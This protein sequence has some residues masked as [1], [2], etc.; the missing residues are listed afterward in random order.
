MVRAQ[1]L[2]T[3]VEA[4]IT[5]K[6]VN[7]SRFRQFRTELR[8]ALPKAKATCAGRSAIGLL[9]S[10]RN[11]G[12]SSGARSPDGSGGMSKNSTSHAMRRLLRNTSMRTDSMIATGTRLYEATADK[13]YARMQDMPFHDR[14]D[15][16]RSWDGR[17][18]MHDHGERTRTACLADICRP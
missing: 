9:R 8:I 18:T 17:A 3:R 6:L 5:A 2:L 4:A 7:V 14:A 15:N 12:W 11:A 13:A 10:T 16:I 1:S